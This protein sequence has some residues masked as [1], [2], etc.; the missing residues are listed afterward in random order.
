MVKVLWSR[1]VRGTSDLSVMFYVL[2][3]LSGTWEAVYYCVVDTM[4]ML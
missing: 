2:A 3:W 4:L 1:R